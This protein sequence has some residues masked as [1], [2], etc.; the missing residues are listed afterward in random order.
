MTHTYH[1]TPYDISAT[2]FYFT[3]LEDYQAKAATHRNDYGQPVEEYEIQ[4]IDGEAAP[5]FNA[6]EVNQV[7]L[8]LWFEQFEDLDGEDAVK[9]IYLADDR[10][11]AMAEIPD[12]LEDVILFEGNARAYAEEYLESTGLL[13][14]MPENLRFYFDVDAFARDLQLGGDITEI[15]IDGT[16]YVV[17]E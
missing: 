5:L 16:T 11:Y 4:Y 1:A 7:T 12:R 2:G 17:S 8:A 14:Q 13:D 6:L 3:N 10:G 15:D 9:A